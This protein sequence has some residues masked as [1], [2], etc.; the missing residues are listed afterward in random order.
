MVLRANER[1]AREGGQKGNG[2]VSCLNC[3]V[4]ELKVMLHGT[5]CNDDFSCNTALQHCCDI[6]SHSCNID[7]TLQRCVG[8]ENFTQKVNLCCFIL[9]HIYSNSFNL[10]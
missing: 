2:S 1:D 9:D 7:L 8:R 4:T 5:I 3:V 10:K 6:V